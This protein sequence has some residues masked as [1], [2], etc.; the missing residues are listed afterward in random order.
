MHV[1]HGL[2][3]ILRSII[4]SRKYNTDN[5]RGFRD[6]RNA[7]RDAKKSHNLRSATLKASVRL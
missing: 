6:N 1:G 4:L 7:F 2:K 3:L 5:L